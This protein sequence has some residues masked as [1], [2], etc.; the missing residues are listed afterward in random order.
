MVVLDRIATQN[1]I[2]LAN[3]S[4]FQPDWDSFS[5]AR[6]VCPYTDSL[7]SSYISGLTSKVIGYIVY[8]K[9]IGDS[10]LHKVGEVGRDCYSIIDHLVVNHAEYQYLVSPITETELGISMQ[11]EPYRT[12]WNDWTLTSLWEVSTN[13]FCPYEIWNLSLNISASEMQQNIDKTVFKTYSKYP[14]ISVGSSDYIT[15][16]FTCLLGRIDSITEEYKDTADMIVAF[17]NMVASD[18]P[19]LMKDTK[20]QSFLISI[21]STS[22]SV[23]DN[24][25][26]QPT[27]LS[28]SYTQ[29]GNPN[30]ILVFEEGE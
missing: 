13:V 25:Y 5:S 28:F 12:D 8:R 20:G 26:E 21:D 17:R 1:E 15:G 2:A 16:N 18:R 27:T 22:I 10:R 24:L 11:T 9:K 3:T 7:V 19:I 23:N 4:D 14:K 6:I 30:N 29:I